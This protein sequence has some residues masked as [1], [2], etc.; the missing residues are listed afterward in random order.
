MTNLILSRADLLLPIDK[1]LRQVTQVY[2]LGFMIDFVFFERGY[3][4]IN[5]KLR[6][7][8]GH[9]VVKIFSKG[10][11]K[12][13]I[14]D[15]IYGLVQFTQAG[16]PVPQLKMFGRNFL[17]NF[18]GF[19]NQAY[20]C[21]MEFFEGSNFTEIKSTERDFLSV[22]KYLAIINN[23]HFSVHPNYDS[24]GTA[25]LVQEFT[26]KRKF[27][28]IDDK[29]RIQ[30]VVNEFSKID[31]QNFIQSVIHGDIQR[32]HVLKDRQGN[33]CILDLGCMNYAASILDMAI[34]LSQF[35]IDIKSSIDLQ[36][37]VTLTTFEYRKTNPIPK[38]EFNHLP[39][40]MS[41]TY[42]AYL[43][44]ASYE[45]NGKDNASTESLNWREFGRKGL[46]KLMSVK[47]AKT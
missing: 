43:I 22:A 41:A 44:A 23:Q 7:Q 25:N 30:I 20:L 40:F 39:L 1:L 15:Y 18:P 17:Y 35:T 28:E 33:Y 10:R 4:D 32:E 31:L 11:T 5:I 12:K 13:Q 24:W 47:L 8:K 37:I 45:I 34:F 21:V 16:I 46:E 38:K 29:K 19:Q 9:Y 36:N 27:L 3:E 42:A 26:N 14:D 2:Q 6:T